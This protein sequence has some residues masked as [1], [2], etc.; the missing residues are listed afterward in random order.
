VNT[1]QPLRSKRDIERMKKALG[2][3]RDRL[4]F[5]FGINSSLRIS[6]ILRLKVGDVRG[7]ST[8]TLREKKTGKLKKFRLNQSVVSAVQQLVPAD[9]SDND[10]LFPSR[11]GARPITR[12]QAY[13]ILTDAARRAGLDIEIGTH[14]LRKTFAY[15]AY[16]AGV[17]LALLMSVLNHSS[18]R[19][20]LRYIGITQDQVDDVFVSVNL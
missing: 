20:T 11:K 14:T 1:V 6:D 17:D 4:L 19:E 10:W 13:R 18:Q 2:N 12:V 7:K 9:A 8:L 16:K 15:H 5:I 3:P